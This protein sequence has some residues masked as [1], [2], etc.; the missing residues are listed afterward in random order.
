MYVRNSSEA[1][2]R[3]REIRKINCS[4]DEKSEMMDALLPFDYYSKGVNPGWVGVIPAINVCE[5]IYEVAKIYKG[6]SLSNS[7]ALEW[8]SEISIQMHGVMTGLESHSESG[9]VEETL[10]RIVHLWVKSSTQWIVQLVYL[11]C[12]DKAA[13][14]AWILLEG[15]YGMQKTW[16]FMAPVYKQTLEYI[17]KE[18]IEALAMFTAMEKNPMQIVYVSALD[19]LQELDSNN[20]DLR[21]YRDEACRTSYLDYYRKSIQE[22]SAN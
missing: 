9:N 14:V 8:F 21:K 4:D 2:E 22:L 13:T 5:N 18:L 19:K 16:S 12:F 1:L 15:L 17:H 6:L 10:T 7:K 20:N 11:A 3:V